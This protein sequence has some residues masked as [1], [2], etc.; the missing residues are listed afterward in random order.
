MRFAQPPVNR[1]QPSPSTRERGA[2]KEC[3]GASLG[4]PSRRRP[5]SVSPD[6][7]IGGNS[8]LRARLQVAAKER[9]AA[10]LLPRSRRFGL[11][12][13]G[14]PWGALRYAPARRAAPPSRR[15]EIRVAAAAVLALPLAK[16]PTERNLRASR[17]RGA[18]T[19]IR[20]KPERDVPR[21]TARAHLPSWRGSHFRDL[22]PNDSFHR[23]TNPPSR[24]NRRPAPS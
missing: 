8:F 22:D 18:P 23:P 4:L 13:G 12:Q 11:R 7:D 24:Q 20:L 14:V 1:A 19:A 17:R 2:W 3:V 16:G 15:R 10:P 21:W 6:L 9:P 5:C